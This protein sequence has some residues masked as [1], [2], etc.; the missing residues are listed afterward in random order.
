MS[1]LTK[2][3]CGKWGE[4]QLFVERYHL[5]NMLSNR[6]V[7][8]NNDN[9]VMHLRKKFQCRQKKLILDKFLAKKARKATAE[10]EES[11]ASMRQRRE[12]TQKRTITQ[13][14]HGGSLR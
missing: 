9:A 13:Y 12:K 8:I 1:S 3:M 7:H 2:E 10:E 6:A 11:T 5:D 4:V 14:F